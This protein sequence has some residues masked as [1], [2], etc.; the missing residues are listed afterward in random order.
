M[1]GLGVHQW[2]TGTRSGTACGAHTLQRACTGGR[3]VGG[4]ADLM[5]ERVC[6]GVGQQLRIGEQQRPRP[7]LL[8]APGVGQD[9]GQ[10]GTR[11]RICVNTPPNTLG[12]VAR[13]ACRQWDA[14][15][16]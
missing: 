1:Q 14:P 2:E 5:G 16:A 4:G 15:T 8:A 9:L 10:G 7:H 11:A 3:G 12:K 13:V 6:L